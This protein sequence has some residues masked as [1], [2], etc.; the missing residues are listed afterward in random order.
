MTRIDA[1]WALLM[2]CVNF[3]GTLPLQQEG[4]YR[5]PTVIRNAM[6]VCAHPPI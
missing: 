4:T 2:G 3:V 1:V 5:F 6:S